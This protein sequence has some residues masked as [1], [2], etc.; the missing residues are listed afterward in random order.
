MISINAIII[1]KNNTFRASINFL[2]WCNVRWYHGQKGDL[3][4]T[5]KRLTLVVAAAI[6]LS[7]CVTAFHT[8]PKLS[9]EHRRIV[10][11]APDVE[12]S[13]LNAGGIT[14]PNAA[15]TRDAKRLIASTLEA[16][17]RGINA[18]LVRGS[19]DALEAANDPRETQL[20]KLHGAVGNSILLHQYGDILQLPTKKGKFEWGLGPDTA[21]L[22]DKYGA[23][24]AL[25]IFIR[26]SY[27]SGGRVA[28]I[29]VAAVLGVGLQGGVQV[30]F[31][32]LVDLR[33]GDIVWF[34]RLAR[35]VGDLRTPKGAKETVDVLLKDF[36]G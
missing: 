14:E 26:D 12:L 11:L 13:L 17:F 36:P 2:L 16:R 18:T 34:N 35:G 1:N 23:D 10:L 19:A 4:D 6:F 29:M 15:W 21:Y 3:G 32:S 27:A 24:Y 33:S 28:A 25:F 31:A 30:G 9:Q 20:V 5:L 8:M 7:G 22:K